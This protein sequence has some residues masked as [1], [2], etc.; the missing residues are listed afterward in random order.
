MHLMPPVK[1]P[2]MACLAQTSIAYNENKIRNQRLRKIISY[3]V[4]EHAPALRY[5]CLL[6]GDVFFM[7][8]FI[9]TSCDA[10]GNFK[11]Y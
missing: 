7:F 9:A 2:N 8:P 3:V 6:S 4:K 5:S 10:H 11:I 1:L